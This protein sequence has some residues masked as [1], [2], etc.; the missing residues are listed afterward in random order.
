MGA[1]TIFGVGVDAGSNRTRVAVLEVTGDLVRL[2][3]YGETRSEGWKR[4]RIAD[5]RA[6]AESIRAAVR[7]AERSAQIPVVSAVLGAGGAAVGCE[8]SSRGYEDDYRRKLTQADV[9]LVIERAAHVQLGEDRMLLHL[10]LRE[11]SVDGR[12]GYRD[13]RG[14]SGVSLQAHVSLITFSTR[15]HDTLVGAANQAGLAV[16]ETVYEPVAAAYACLRAEHRRGGVMLV[17]IGAESADLVVY[18]GDSLVR[19]SSLELGGARFT[20]DTADGLNITLVDAEA[21]KLQ[22]GSAVRDPEAARSLIELPAPPGRQPRTIPREELAFILECRAEQ[23]FRW[24]RRELLRICPEGR[25]YGGV[26]LCG[27]AS[28]LPGMCDVAEA[29]VGLDAYLGLPAGIRGWPPA[30]NDPAWTTVAG[31]AMYSARLKQRERERR[32]SLFSRIF[33]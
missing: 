21:V 1:K 20:E 24:V 6:V 27:G 10:C 16:E 13:P 5:A 28:R 23:L 8:Y 12:R 32:R 18:M 2:A 19:A 3:G 7:E 15:E 30:L 4:S 33:G 11:F 25:L 14:Q 22:Y 26:V 17:D 9:N 29:V 31:L